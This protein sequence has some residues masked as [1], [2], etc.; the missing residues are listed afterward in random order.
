MLILVSVSIWADEGAR[1]LYSITADVGSQAALSGPAL[2]SL[3]REMESRFSAYNGLFRFDPSEL[4]A[5]LNIRVF[6]GK[7]EYDRYLLGL[8]GNGNF[9]PEA[10]YLHYRESENRELVVNLQSPELSP[11]LSYQA[12]IQ[13]FRAFIPNPPAWMLEGFAIFF[14]TIRFDKN[15]ALE[16]EENLTWLEPVKNMRDKLPSPNAILLADLWDILHPG[17][18]PPIDFGEFQISSWALVS[19]LL[20]SGG[21]Y[22]R[23]LTDSFMLLSPSAGA[24]EN[25]L[26]VTRRF[27]SWNDFNVM[28]NDFRTYLASRKT[29]REIMED[30]NRA[31]SRG[32]YKSAELS[33]VSANQ[34]R[35]SDFAPYYY[36]G[37]IS[38]AEKNYDA[39]EQFYLASLERGA[40]AALV[41]YALGINAAAAGRIQ[42]PVDYM[43]KAAALDPTRYSSRVEDVLRRIWR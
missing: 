3:L 38:Y 16:Y 5:P 20:N 42:D 24:E 43:Y 6:S 1:P 7:E 4:D 31:Y 33:F 39:A 22:F 28:N 19:F 10:M 27:S 26:N 41:N 37:L 12:F 25:S 18:L 14:S 32:D 21:E 34:Q 13:Y 11:A 30:G 9:E 2:S 36:L 15:G 40:D 8:L 29:F 17:V 23:T 35:P